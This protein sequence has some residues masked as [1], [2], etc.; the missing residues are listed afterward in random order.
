M[1]MDPDL[2]EVDSLT[3]EQ[4][5]E[6][7]GP[8]IMDQVLVEVGPMTMEQDSILQIQV[9][10]TNL[11]HPTNHLCLGNLHNRSNSR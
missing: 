6:E 2:I 3:Q 1:I 9:E 4:G 11:V 5:L 7:V 8:L 10:T